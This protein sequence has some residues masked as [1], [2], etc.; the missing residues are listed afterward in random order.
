MPVELYAL[1]GNFFQ[2]NLK[3]YFKKGFKDRRVQTTTKWKFSHCPVARYKNVYGYINKFTTKCEKMVPNAQLFFF[4]TTSKNVFKIA[5]A[6]M[7][8]LE[9]DG[10]N[11][12]GH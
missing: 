1:T 4:F 12:N 7:F 2:K 5:A 11:K 10:E 3:S 6:V 9:F 8:M